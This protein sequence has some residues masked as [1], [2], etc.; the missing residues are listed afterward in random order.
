M[1]EH[2]K[3]PESQSRTLD[4]N[5]KASRQAPIDVILQRYKERNI[6]RYADDEEFIQ[7]KFDSVQREKIDEDELLQGK[8][9]STL[10][11]VQE[12]VQRE[13]RPN[14]TGLP[15]NLKTGIE[16]LSGYSM[17]DVRVHYNS[18]KPAQLQALAYAQ[19]TDIHVAPGLEKHL[20]H[21]AWHVVQQKQGRVQPTVQ[22]Q[23]VSVNDNEGLEKEADMMGTKANESGLSYS[24]T[25]VFQRVIDSSV[26]QLQLPQG[27][28]RL[29]NKFFS[30]NL[31]SDDAQKTVSAK[32]SPG[33]IV[34][35]I[36]KGVRLSNFKAG[37]ITNEHSWVETPND[38]QGW[39]E[40]SMMAM[41]F[42]QPTDTGSFVGN[43]ANRSNYLKELENHV[44]LGSS[45][46]EQDHVL[47]VKDAR[48]E[49]AATR[50]NLGQQAQ[51][52]H[53]Q[54]A[55]NDNQNPDI[56]NNTIANHVAKNAL[57]NQL[58]P[59]VEHGLN[60]QQQPM[61]DNVKLKAKTALG[62]IVATTVGYDVM[63]RI[64]NLSTS[65]NIPI[66]YIE[67]ENQQVY[68]LYVVPQ[69][70]VLNN[71]ALQ[72]ITVRLPPDNLFTDAQS[73]KRISTQNAL[74]HSDMGQLGRRI[75]V[76][77]VDTDLLHEFTHALHYLTFEQRRRTV[78]ANHIHDQADYNFET[79]GQIVL[80]NQ[81][82]LAEART[83]HRNQSF[84]NLQN[85]AG[86]IID[87]D[88]PV[89]QEQYNAFTRLAA[90]T[91]LI[92]T[93]NDYRAELGLGAR[94]DHH[95][96]RKDV[97]EKFKQ[98]GLHRITSV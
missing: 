52:G 65:L 87:P 56:Y 84:G 96:M 25:P 7:G 18:P 49:E 48:L 58:H 97:D 33:T 8:F 36:S 94:Q 53:I 30:T 12:P 27:I 83:I 44:N 9:E 14:D 78:A 13:E 1:R 31:R 6:Q 69:F 76:S 19:G 86:G 75:S 42:N 62:Q 63:N 4:S 46:N 71:N 45:F 32:L 3:K 59:L 17:D 72:S 61:S 81:D 82:N 11:D 2:V 91:N 68:N 26:T 60:T 85:I 15:D 51:I 57:W 79:G 66:N 23:G 92:P 38:G 35:V 43:L 77:P 70:D 88:I 90:S 98:E 80:C 24:I 21:E 34:K 5:P 67:E 89:T 54:N 22:M 16:N 74:G 55:F 20:P 73:F 93:E 10:T 40:D 95:A 37:W 64:N 39:I 41:A 28:Y 29:K 50:L 47:T